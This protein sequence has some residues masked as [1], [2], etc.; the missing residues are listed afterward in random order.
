MFGVTAPKFF[1]Y[2]GVTG[3]PKPR[4]VGSCSDRPIGR[5]KQ[6]DDEGCFPQADRWMDR[7]RKH[8]LKTDAHPG[9]FGT[10][11]IVDAPDT[12]PQV[13]VERCKSIEPVIVEEGQ[14]GSRRQ[15]PEWTAQS[16][17]FHPLRQRRGDS[18]IARVRPVAQGVEALREAQ[19]G[20]PPAH[21]LRTALAADRGFQPIAFEKGERRVS[22]RHRRYCAFVDDRPPINDQAINSSLFE[23]PKPGGVGHGLDA[24]RNGDRIE[25]GDLLGANRCRQPDSAV[26][27]V[28]VNVRDDEGFVYR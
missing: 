17:T 26:L 7:D 12:A 27:A 25:I 10:V 3:A 11:A 8:A 19:S 16:R 22:A 23:G 15:G 4:E 18:R 24:A 21:R 9:L 2:R 1:S 14:E 28:A 13:D 20:A 5:R 6:F